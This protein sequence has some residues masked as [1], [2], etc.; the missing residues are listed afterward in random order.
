VGSGKTTLARVLTGELSPSAGRILVNGRDL[1]ELDLREYRHR[2]G[3]IPQEAL[4]FSDTVRENVSFG[5]EAAD[6]R[7]EE[8][9]Q[10]A[11]VDEEVAAFP[12]GLDELLGQR[13]VR[14][15][16]GQRQRL[17]VA[18]ALVAGPDLLVMDD[19]TAALDAENEEALWDAIEAR[20]PGIGGVVVTHRI[21][22]ARR[23]D[24]I[25]VLDRGRV[26]DRGTHDEL[27]ARCGLYRRLAGHDGPG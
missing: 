9:L 6:E 1:A 5:R 15:S 23:A 24:S 22:T 12:K 11:Q 4:L 26:V 13:G 16:G 10:V 3:Y 25:V 20:H 14:V 18:R 21:A 27:I 7:I 2:V 8:V 17:A 19:V